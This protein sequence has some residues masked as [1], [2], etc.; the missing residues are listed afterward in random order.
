MQNE[1]AKEFAL[2]SAL[3]FS[4]FFFWCNLCLRFN[5]ISPAGQRYAHPLPDNTYTQRMC[6][7]TCSCRWAWTNSESF[8]RAH[9]T[10]LSAAL[11]SSA[12]TVRISIRPVGCS[13]S[14][15]AR[16]RTMQLLPALA[17]PGQSR[18]LC[19]QEFDG[20]HI[21]KLTAVEEQEE[22]GEERR[23]IVCNG[24]VAGTG[25]AAMSVAKF[26]TTFIIFGLGQRE[27]S[28][29]FKVQH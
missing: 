28:R 11:G 26:R 1:N 17:S 22:K 5:S 14:T 12:H 15:L 18:C 25:C 10:C 13:P 2:L 16:L 20:A 27:F 24:Q 29:Q 4:L 6:S 9:A 7:A 23:W 3:L 8:S 19:S 21:R